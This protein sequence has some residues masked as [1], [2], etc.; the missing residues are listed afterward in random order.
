MKRGGGSSQGGVTL[1]VYMS[2]EVEAGGGGRGEGA[3]HSANLWLA[4]CSLLH[5]ALSQHILPCRFTIP[6][7]HT[8]ACAI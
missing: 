2:F 4:I 5:Q 1:Y 6:C 8:M 3:Q 7:C